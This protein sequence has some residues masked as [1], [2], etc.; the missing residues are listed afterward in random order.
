MH[1]NPLGIRFVIEQVSVPIA[2][3]NRQLSLVGTFNEWDKKDKGTLS[4]N[5]QLK[6]TTRPLPP[7]S[8][9][10]QCYCFAKFF[11]AFILVA[12]HPFLWTANLF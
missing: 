2:C 10:L 5:V 4:Q 11:D 1:C 7:N 6:K 3:R 9:Q 12:T 8:F